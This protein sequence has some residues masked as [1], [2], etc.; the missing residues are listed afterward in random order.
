MRFHIP[1]NACII[2]TPAWIRSTPG[3]EYTRMI[4]GG[5]ITPIMTITTFLTGTIIRII[6][7]GIVTQSLKTP[8]LSGGS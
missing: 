5:M 1:T 2:R 3:M 4:Y 8:G 6:C 7:G